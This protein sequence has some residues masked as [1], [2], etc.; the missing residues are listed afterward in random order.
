MTDSLI[1]WAVALDGGTSNTRARLID[2]ADGRV[3]AIARR[4][5]GAR[6]TVLAG[7]DR[8]L[9]RAV[10]EALIEVERRAD[11][12]RPD[13][14][15]AA[16]MLSAEVGLSPVPHVIAPAGLDELARG[17]VVRHLPAIADQPILFVPGVR[18]P[19]NSGLDGWARADVMRG[20]ECETL[21]A[22]RHL[23]ASTETDPTGPRAP[24]A[25]VFLWP[26]SHTKLVEVDQAGRIVRS[27]TTLAGEMI[28]AMARHTLLA[29]SLPETWP[30]ALDPEALS[31]AVRLVEREGL[32]RAA[33]L[34]RVAALTEALGLRERAS[35]WI[36]AV[37]ADDVAHLVRHPILERQSPVWVGGRQPLRDLYATQ[38]RRWHEAPVVAIDDEATEA[39]SAL[40]ALAVARRFVELHTGGI[41]SVSLGPT[42]QIGSKTRRPAR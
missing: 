12:V 25:T 14:I 17:A 22:W 41:S 28:Q 32:G 40:G 23:A 20:E 37:V 3:V 35:F 38:L 7:E 31:A 33:F 36:G 9:E 30:D 5:V 15:V 24:A 13:V 2:A 29:A 10:R 39:A 18:T 1:S 27:Q 6:D 21:G 26:G 34:V 16:G 19:A 42:G 8:P 11:G 4:A